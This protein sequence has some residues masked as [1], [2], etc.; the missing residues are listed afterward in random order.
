[1]TMLNSSRSTQAF[2]TPFLFGVATADHQC[3]AYDPRFEDIR[4]VW[5]RKR[6]L[7][8]RK[9]A[10]DFWNRY[11]GDIQLA[12]EL[13]CNSFRFS[14]A[15]S[16]LEPVAGQFNDEAFD[17][18]RQLIETVR[19]AGMEPVM[20]LHHF[21]WPVHV[22]ERGGLIGKD[23]PAIYTN[24]VAEVVKRLGQQVRYWITF[25]EPTQL[26]YGYIKPWWEQYYFMPPGLP[27]HATFA[28]QLDAVGTLMRNLFQAHTAARQVIKQSNPDALV[29]VNPLILGLPVWLQRLMDW[30]I[31][32]LHSREDWVRRGLSYS[33]RRL[34]EH[35][36]VDI[37]LGTLTMTRRRAEQVDFSDAYFVTSQAL[38]VN[39]GSAIHTILDLDGA[40]VAVVEHST[41]PEA[42]HRHLPKA[43]ALVVEHYA[44]A[45]QALDSG[46]AAAILTDDTILQGLMKQHPGCYRLLDTLSTRE[47]YAA[48]VAKGHP[49]LLAV[50]NR[51]VRSFKDTQA[52][53]SSIARHL[54]GQSIAGPPHLSLGTT[55]ADI[56]GWDS[57]HNKAEETG[58]TQNNA[59]DTLLDRIKARGY[60][61]VA[62]KENVPGFG[63]RDPQTGEMSGLEI[64]L[65]RA[66]AQEIFGDP[67]KV[68]F[69]PAQTHERLP[70]VRSFLR[71]FDAPIKLYSIIST[72]LNSNWWHLGMAGKL[73]E[74]LCPSE[75]VGQQDFVG[76]DYY[77]GI[78]TLGLHRIQELLSAMHGYYD[79]APVWP[80]ELYKTLRYHARL[81]PGKE[82]L[83][84]ENG[85]VDAADGYDRARYIECHVQEVQRAYQSGVK[86]L[87]YDCWSITSNRE[88]GLPFNR[89]SDFGLYHIDLDNDPELKRV[90]TPAVEVYKR[91]IEQRGE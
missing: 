33:R 43:H 4:D 72:A 87:G 23:F 65:A 86:V 53:T 47:Y 19:S 46:K 25:N 80:G 68:V 27:E 60:L 70:L 75:C 9:R 26:I 21:T 11:T 41:A 17:H 83:I 5:E 48:A 35:G 18:Y 8:E 84:I 49:E 42:L 16:R 74:F 69:H 1:M 63:Y 85:C 37:V 13:G 22:E 29:G 73:P 31:T 91:I 77:W 52:W 66:I 67:D 3:E 45:L 6:N 81:F 2:P 12:K 76:L 20:T 51:A 62:V 14:L 79:Q 89:G 44:E 7:T 88:W 64:D 78:S 28:D 58:S 82:V 54:S 90:P 59:R 50:V 61:V 55:L 71:F 40:S 30:N 57:H 39:A 24:Y 10:T 36:K 15:W 56:N 34:S 32:R 38:L